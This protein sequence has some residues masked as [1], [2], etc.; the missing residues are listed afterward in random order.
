MNM[1]GT[2]VA[3]NPSC[4]PVSLVLALFQS[5]FLNARYH[6]CKAASHGLPSIYQRHFHTNI[7]M[8]T[9][10]VQKNYHNDETHTYALSGAVDDRLASAII[11]IVTRTAPL[12]IWS[13]LPLAIYTLQPI[14]PICALSESV[15]SSALQSLVQQH[16][17]S[18]R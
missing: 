17:Y 12:Q 13:N 4:P 7:C 8:P 1:P 16:C 10:S 5:S 18:P 15:V 9:W 11:S 14:A 6:S 3:S 2:M